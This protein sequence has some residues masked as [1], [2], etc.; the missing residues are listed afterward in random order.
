M[1]TGLFFAFPF[2]LMMVVRNISASTF[3]ALFILYLS[4]DCAYFAKRD[5]LIKTY[6]TPYSEMA[7]IIRNGSVRH[8]AILAVD[9]YGSFYEP[10]VQKVGN[11]V[12]V[13][14]LEDE[15]SAELVRKAALQG[16]S[17]KSVIWLWRHTRDISPGAFVSRLEEDLGEG[18]KMQRYDFMPY[19]P[20]ERWIRRLLR[21]P[22]Q[23]EFYYRLSEVRP[24]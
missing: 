13:I 12:R 10:L 5:F 15:A 22:G 9:S 14:P 11:G 1:P 16:S 23:A 17:T 3:A 7:Q 4:A 8:N 20:A 6:A 21:G 24:Q 2:F 18:R 19:S